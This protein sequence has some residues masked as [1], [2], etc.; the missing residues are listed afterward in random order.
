M[1]ER[2]ELLRHAVAT[3]A[4]RAAKALREAPAG[5]GGFD[6][7]GSVRTPVALVAHV[8]DL[9]V[10][11]LSLAE[12]RG[13]WRPAVPLPWEEEVER[14]FSSIAAFDAYL[15]SD[16]PLACDVERLLQGPVADALTHVGQIMLLRRL[17]GANVK[18][19]NYFK[20]D[21]APGRVGAEQTPARREFD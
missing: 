5:F 10:W 14:F 4:Y 1:D 15:A 16:K 11:S 17:A 20:A 8:G 2:R 3:V 9:F 13:E 6:P 21:V 12:G 7:G 19:E 18:S